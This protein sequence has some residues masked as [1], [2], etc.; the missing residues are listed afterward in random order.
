MSKFIS[1]QGSP[2]ELLVTAD[3]LG[4]RLRVHPDTV[5]NWANERGLPHITLPNQ[6]FRFLFSEVEAWLKKFNKE[7]L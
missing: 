7:S 3:E 5:R 1:T 2:A 6:S 4:D